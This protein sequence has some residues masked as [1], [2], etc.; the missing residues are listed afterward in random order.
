[1]FGSTRRVVAK[2][3]KSTAILWE[4]VTL[5]DE[6]D[7]QRVSEHHHA[8]RS[9][10]LEWC[11]EITEISMGLL[12]YVHYRFAGYLGNASLVFAAMVPTSL[13]VRSGI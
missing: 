12:W 6:K 5:D 11:D 7:W 13:E 3:R 8:T 2:P 4:G 1:M 9:D 10:Y